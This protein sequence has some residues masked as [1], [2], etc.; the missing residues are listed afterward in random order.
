M[1]ADIIFFFFMSC[2]LIKYIYRSN[3]CVIQS[4]LIS[5]STLCLGE[6]NIQI[7]WFCDKNMN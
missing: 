5:Y 1:V 6:L 4:T 2:G 7:Q 3:A